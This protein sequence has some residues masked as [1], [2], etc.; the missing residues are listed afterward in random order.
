MPG[1][2]GHG[3]RNRLAAADHVLSAGPHREPERMPE[4]HLLRCERSSGPDQK[5]RG[6]DTSFGAGPDEARKRP[7]AG[8]AARCS[9][10]AAGDGRPMGAAGSGKPSSSAATGSY[11]TLPGTPTVARKPTLPGNPRDP[12]CAPRPPGP[13]WRR[14]SR[15]RRNPPNRPGRS[16]AGGVPIATCPIPPSTPAMP[17]W[18]IPRN[19]LAL[20]REVA[21]PTPGVRIRR[22][23]WFGA[24]QPSARR[25]R[26]IR[27]LSEDARRCR[28]LSASRKGPVTAYPRGKRSRRSSSY[29]ANR[30]WPSSECPTLQPGT[31]SRHETPGKTPE[32]KERGHARSCFTAPDRRLPEDAPSEVYATRRPVD[33]AGDLDAEHSMWNSG[34]A[35]PSPGN[36]AFRP[37]RR[38]RSTAAV[39]RDSFPPA[40]G[41]RRTLG[42]QPAGAAATPAGGPRRRGTRMRR[43]EIS[44]AF[45]ALPL[46]NGASPVES[47]PSRLEAAVHD[48]ADIPREGRSLKREF[49]ERQGRWETWTPERGTPKAR[50]WAATTGYPEGEPA[51]Q[52]SPADPQGPLRRPSASHSNTARYAGVAVRCRPSAVEPARAKRQGL[53]PE[54]DVQRP[55]GNQPQTMAMGSHVQRT[56]KI[57]GPVVSAR[58]RHPAPRRRSG[59]PG[60]PVQLVAGRSG[61]RSGRANPRPTRRGA[62]RMLSQAVRATTSSGGIW[63]RVPDDGDTT[64]EAS[65]VRAHGGPGGRTSE[66]IRL[67]WGGSG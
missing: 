9:P 5:T 38:P 51:R 62:R 33:L 36:T 20:G 44:P 6:A 12:G 45:A 26:D 4:V 7:P 42:R 47:A 61:G 15:E 3:Q 22:L 34:R 10:H 49:G 25:R 60:P 13:S 1:M 57:G 8:P 11:A 40:T 31:D 50:G 59:F 46:P 67:R 24:S 58:I 43:T 56:Q 30:T 37:A 32:E 41:S 48:G 54:R 52:G 66:R 2:N 23:G 18:R 19:D 39:G 27:H 55:A 64:S 35:N 16:P 17:T 29:D 53:S 21:C 63:S 28:T 65:L 14:R